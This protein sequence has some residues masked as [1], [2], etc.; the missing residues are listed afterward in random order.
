MSDDEVIA[1]LASKAKISDGGKKLTKKELRK[2]KKAD[3]F[4]NEMK[5]MGGK[6]EQEEEARAREEN[7]DEHF[8]G[9]GIGGSDELGSHGLPASDVRRPSGRSGEC[10]RHQSGELDIA[11]NGRQ[12][13]SKATLTIS[14]GH[15]YG[16]VGPNGMGKT[17]LLRHIAQR[18]FAAIPPIDILYCEQE[19]EVDS[20]SAVETV[21]RSDKKRTEL[22]EEEE[23]ARRRQ[24]SRARGGDY[25]HQGGHRGASRYQSGRRGTSRPPNPGRSWILARD[26]GEG[27]RLVL[28]RLAHAYLARSRPVLGANAP[29]ARRTHKPSRPKRCYLARPLPAV[30]EENAVDSFPRPRFLGQRVHGHG[31]ARGHEAALLQGKLLEF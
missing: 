16:L 27:L 12:L 3:A 9:R 25:S 10:E 20:T 13:F 28:R 17:T 22:L 1:D 7:G 5:A 31:P 18:K 21:L 29:H 6:V 4:K 2:Q 23:E 30:V 19:I 14:A 26:A 11:A 24:R 8:E 15:R